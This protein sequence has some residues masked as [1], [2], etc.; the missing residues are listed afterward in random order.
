MNL[1][2]FIFVKKT[3]KEEED[4]EKILSSKLGDFFINDIGNYVY[5]PKV[6]DMGITH[7]LS[8]IGI[9]DKGYLMMELKPNNDGQKFFQNLKIK[10]EIITRN[11]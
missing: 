5:A 11:I 6:Y 9:S 4:E 10:L 2:N 8:N 7:K 3:K 1:G